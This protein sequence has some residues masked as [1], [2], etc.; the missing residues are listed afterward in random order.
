MDRRT[1]LAVAG[2]TA[3][4]AGCIS[5]DS[6]ED[7]DGGE[8]N[9]TNNTDEAQP[10]NGTT[11]DVDSEDAAE[12]E[13]SDEDT[14]L[15]V[16]NLSDLDALPFDANVV[17]EFEGEGS[18]V[19]DRFELDSGMTMLVFESENVEGEGIA[20]D[21]EQT[22][23]DE[24]YVLAINEIVRF[25]DSDAIDEV[26]GASLIQGG[27][28]E[29]LLDIDTD[30]AWTVHIAQPRAPSE[31][32][33]TLPVSVSGENSAVVGPVEVTNGMTVTGQHQVEGS[34]HGFDV[35]SVPEDAT[36][37]LDSD[38]AFT[39]DGGFE[40][41]SRVDVDGVTWTYV[42]TRGEWSLEFEE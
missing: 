37:L 27:G 19:T 11:A 35:L 14:L 15:S 28:G 22:D 31:E 9:E 32:V 40:G 1:F 39:E 13:R 34:D 18:R 25:E 10:N 16:S 6:Q 8:G 38:Y 29:Y 5:G 3:A 20:A 42:R 30:G 24:S 2:G 36:D 21:I 23:G 4:V 12:G 26:T 33:R 41:Q 17:A 7:T